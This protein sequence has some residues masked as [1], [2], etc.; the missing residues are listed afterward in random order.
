MHEGHC[1]RVVHAE[2]NALLHADREELNNASIYITCSPCLR[3]FMTI[4]NTGISNIYYEGGYKEHR[5][6]K[7]DRDRLAGKNGIDITNLEEVLT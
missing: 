2:I 6:E 4:A 3:C 5:E 7:S 1:L